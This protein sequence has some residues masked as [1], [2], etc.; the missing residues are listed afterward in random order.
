MAAAGVDAVGRLAEQRQA[1]Q[2]AVLAQVAG[3]LS[4]RAGLLDEGEPTACDVRLDR[5]RRRLESPDV[6]AGLEVTG[7]VRSAVVDRGCRRIVGKVGDHGHAEHLGDLGVSVR[8]PFADQEQ[9][10]VPPTG[11][12][13]ADRLGPRA[14]RGDRRQVRASDQQGRVSGVEELLRRPRQPEPAGID[15]DVLPARFEFAQ[16]RAERLPHVA[17]RRCLSVRPRSRDEGDVRAQWPDDVPQRIRRAQRR[18]RQLDQPG[19]VR[20]RALQEPGED[21]G[22]AGR[23]GLD[24]K[25]RARPAEREAHGRRGDAGRSGCG[26]QADD[27]HHSA[28][29]SSTRATFPVAARAARTPASAY[30]T[31]TLTTVLPV[32]SST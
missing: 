1:R 29:E 27:G 26:G 19:V 4:H 31:R 17:E 13:L 10:R 16:S 15:D 21:A 18:E 20:R 5:L 30:G 11:R 6:G 12:G 23:V 3:G 9:A 22:A 8:L 7:R 24:E 2:V 32:V 28:P 25:H 14:C